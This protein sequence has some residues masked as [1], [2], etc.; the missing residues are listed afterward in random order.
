[1]VNDVYLS[2]AGVW[3]QQTND[4]CLSMAQ[5]VYSKMAE[6]QW[7]L[8]EDGYLNIDTDVKEIIYHPSLNV[9]LICTKSGVVRVLD[10]NSGV[11]LQSSYLSAINQ[12]EVKCKYIPAVD[13][14]LF[15]DGQALGVRSDYNG[16]LLLDSILQKTVSDGREEIKLELPLSEAIILKQSLS[17]TN[18][19]GV[20]RMIQEL[21]NVISN[22]QKQY[23]KG[24]KAQKWNTVCVQL[25]LDDLRTAASN[26]VSDLIAKNQHTPELG[27]AS[28]VQER[29]SELMGE[30]VN[31]SDRKS[32][33]SEYRRRETFSHWP[34]MDYKW[35][36]PDQMAQ[37][38]FYHQ[39]NSSG[40]DRAMCF[41][42]TV[43][44]VCWE[45]TDE[46][47]SEHERHSPNCPFVIGEYTQNV[48]LSVTYATSPAID[49]TYRGLNIKILGNSTIPN[50]I[51]TA[52]ADGLISVFDVSGKIKRTHSFYVTQFDS[53]ILE[54]FTQDFGTPGLWTTNEDKKYPVEKKVTALCILND[55]SHKVSGENKT[56]SL[57]PTIVCGLKIKCQSEK[58]MNEQAKISNDANETDMHILDSYQGLSR[59]Y[60]VIYDF[61][62]SKE[63][64]ETENELKQ[65]NTSITYVPIEKNQIVME[66][67]K[68]ANLFDNFDA[69]E[70]E[71]EDLPSYNLMKQL[72]S[73][74]KTL[75]P[76]ESDEVFLP[77]TVTLKKSHTGPRVLT[78]DE[79]NSTKT[80]SSSSNFNLHPLT[81]G[82]LNSSENSDLSISDHIA[83]LKNTQSAKKLNYSR[84]VQCINLPEQCKDYS[85]LEIT[86]I[87]AT[88]DEDHVLVIVK[89]VCSSK[90]F[91]LLYSI[92]VSDRMIKLKEEPVAFR[93]LASFENPVEVHLLPTVDKIGNF[94][95]H[96]S[97]SSIEGNAVLVCIDGSVRIVDLS[98]LKTVCFAKIDDE[99]F[100]SAAYCNSLDRL[101][102]ST[103]KGS[104]HFFALND[105]DNESSDDHEE[106][107]IFGI[108]MDSS[109]AISQQLE[110]LDSSEITNFFREPPDM[111]PLAD[112]KNFRLLCDFEPLRT[113]YCYTKTWR[114]QTD[115]TTW[116]EHIFEVTLPNS[117]LLGH[118]DV[119][120]TLQPSS[121]VPHVEVTLLRQNKSGIGHNLT[122]T[123]PK[124]YKSKIRNLLIHIRAVYSK[125]ETNKN[126]SKNRKFE[127][128]S[129]SINVDKLNL[130]STHKSDFY[131]GCDVLHELSL[132]L[133][134]LKHTDLQHERTQRNLM[135]ESN[136]FVRSLILTAVNTT[137]NE[138]LGIVLDILDWIASIRLSRNRSSNGTPPNQHLEF[139]STIEEHLTE[140][141]HHCVLLGGRS[142]A[143]KCTRLIIT[144]CSG[145]NNISP[146]FGENFSSSVLNALFI[147]LESIN[148]VRSASGLQWIFSL[149]LKVSTKDKEKL[150]SSKCI[151]LLN[152]ISNELVKR[153][154]PYHLILRA[155]YGLYGTPMEPELFDIEPPPYV[156]GGSSST[157]LLTSS[158]NTVATDN[159]P[160]NTDHLSNYS[161]NKESISPKDV[162]STTETKLKY[163]N[164]ASLKIVRGLIETEPLHFS[165]VSASEGTRVERADVSNNSSAVN[166][167]VPFT[168][169]SSGQNSSNKKEDL[170]QLLHNYVEK[171]VNEQVKALNN[172]LESS[173]SSTGEAGHSKWI[174]QIL[175]EAEQVM[176]RK[177]DAIY[178]N[179]SKTLENINSSKTLLQAEEVIPSSNQSGHLPWQQLLVVPPKQV[180]V[181]ERM[182]SAARRHITLD[183]GKPVLLTDILI[184]SCSDLVTVSIDIWLKEDVDEKRLVV[185]TDIGTKNLLLTDLQPPPLCRYMK[186][187]VVGRYGMSTI[188]CRIPL[189]YFYGHIVVLPEEVP[190]DLAQN[191]MSLCSGD[192][193]KQLN[194]LSKLFE[195]IS[196][197]YSLACSKLKELLHPFLVADMKNAVHLSTYMNIMKDKNMNVNNVEHNKVFNAYQET[198]TYQHQL[199]TI[200]N[201][202]AR[203][204]GSMLGNVQY[205]KHNSLPNI[206]TD[207]LTSIAEGLLEV[208]LSIEATTDIKLD[209]CQQFFQALCVS[210]SSR[211]QLLAAIFLEKSCGRMAF[212]GN[213]LADTLAE[214]FSTSC[215]VKFSQDLEKTP[216]KSAVI[217]AA[218]R[219]VFSTL[220]PLFT[221]R[222]SLL[223]VT[224][225]LP[226]LSW[227]LMYLSLQLSLS[228]SPSDSANRW[229]WVLG[230]MVGKANVDS[231]KAGNRKKTCKR[232]APTCTNS[233][234]IS[235]S[236]SSIV[237]GS[238]Q[239]YQSHISK[240]NYETNKSKENKEP[241]IEKPVVSA[242]P[243]FI[244][245]T[246]CLTV[247]KGL[248]KLILS[249]DHSGSADMMLLS[250]KVISRLVTLAKLHLG[251]L[252][253]EHQLLELI[254][255]CI[256][257][258]IPWA[259][260]ALACF[261]QDALELSSLKAEE[262]EMETDASTS[263][264][265]S[266]NDISSEVD[267]ICENF[268]IEDVLIEPTKTNP[269]IN[270]N[271]FPPLPSV[272]ESEDS[273]F[274]ELLEDLEKVRCS[275]KI[276]KST[277]GSS[278][279]ISCAMDSRLELG[280][281][282]AS[283]M[284][285]KKLI[286]RNTHTLLHNI[287]LEVNQKE[288][289][290]GLLPWPIPVE[291]CPPESS[292][293]NHKMLTYCFE[294]LFENLENQVPSKIEHILQ[295]WLTL[296]CPNK[297]EKFDPSMMPQIILKCNSVNHLITTMAWTPGLSLTTWC[298]ALQTLTLVCN[299]NSVKKWFDLSGMAN[300][301]VSHPDFVQLFL[302]LL[303]GSGPIFTGKVLLG[304]VLKTLLLKVVYQ[305]VQPSGPIC[306]RL[307]PLDAQCKLLQSMLYLD[308]SNTDLS[309]AMSTLESTASL[310]HSYVLNIDKIKCISI[311][312]KQ[313]AMTS[314][315]SDIF[316][317][318][319]G[320]DSN[321][322][323]RSV[324]YE[325][326]LILLLKLLGKLI[327]TPIPVL[328]DEGEAMETESPVTSQT[329]ESKAEQIQQDP[330]RAPHTMPC[331]A[332]IVLQ[333]QLTVIRLCRCLAACKSSSLCML[334]NVSQKVAFSN[335]SRT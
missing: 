30:Q 277:N 6:D 191:S 139:V 95:K 250:F 87:L 321:K 239:P 148:K 238:Q 172:R 297:N 182:H 4:K 36:L 327:Q 163:K 258:K 134:S 81:N 82:Q 93:E 146:T 252:L 129:S 123:S 58:I 77:P 183:F 114:L 305:L 208:L 289:D 124:L 72:S 185:A 119:H 125:D 66:N 235:P 71:S 198:I 149:L 264:N 207:K 281:Q 8:N 31:A 168:I 90:S 213:F 99:K 101:C 102:A 78:Y 49:A 180:I 63:Q 278:T 100:V 45:R 167:V 67:E 323:D 175:S 310:V 151:A 188:R 55:K 127:N 17:T 38:G 265:W 231:S 299:M 158:P 181:V 223:A 307:G 147:E 2:S 332:D 105:A 43:C 44:L 298:V 199:N 165:C 317:S 203:I 295:L 33:A 62:Y 242:M 10:V 256:S 68:L 290:N 35:A 174:V 128:K 294:T 308:F 225:D 288:S 220:K 246:H 41:T 266:Q 84:A 283:E 259:P 200:R 106:D 29:L 285:L 205:Q 287:T 15:S 57:R 320:S 179:I 83:E 217:D 173:S 189:G 164:I 326:L 193:E 98:T 76:G 121:T 311:G 319:L 331:F 291:S 262:V 107:D 11:I 136:I 186:I 212:W 261:L 20:D 34:H 241:L 214:L 221:N 9:I 240:K 284:A 263:A 138:V 190:P 53:H 162:L 282:T 156:K 26:I 104:L 300:T 19:S 103:K 270:N 161:F 296:N 314:T 117:T 204:E 120:F 301:I 86:E 302:S 111:I 92:D 286:I 293:S 131:M 192:L 237:M 232:V 292:L 88:L 52:N 324:T 39:P 14:I 37:A 244:D 51:P 47:W 209:L 80:D 333:H 171:Q 70:L 74:Y 178:Q 329:D 176:D 335:L 166:S 79:F 56:K 135:L 23:K 122:L 73:F 110:V 24:I 28:A 184:P 210:Q 116:D 16:V 194:I 154:N 3:G 157:Y 334:A 229:N 316:A 142:I 42:C 245:T 60:L 40:D 267:G 54:R 234:Y 46:P 32:M 273:D 170:Q 115:T 112:L 260:F 304:N 202:M 65:D 274:E 313:N 306:S 69:T 315:F 309:I 219:V 230:E 330:P 211:L 187:T 91:L 21:N 226:L 126:G 144:C 169:S 303:S 253:N 152:K 150:I 216:E 160:P 75:I 113:S 228:R 137:T 108:N 271:S 279:S 22:A 140:L 224:V 85:D 251:Q 269:A 59:L 222:K 280:V 206:S 12:N 196:C 215:A 18:V 236:Y 257:C 255:F 243:Q 7:M 50:L 153:T 64:E 5:D 61:M 254:N 177:I 94:S 27:V 132:T 109:V 218:L 159:P 328:S 89:S 201:V 1:M 118:V 25:P 133:Y 97:I 145:A 233:N 275:S 48:P 248:L 197:R 141:L 227:L 96:A 268:N 272:Y 325:D 322:Q 143:H 249:M 276:N 318:V 13:R 312:E 130:T 195:D 155:R 247:A